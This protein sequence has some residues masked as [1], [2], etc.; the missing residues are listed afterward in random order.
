MSLR[1]LLVEDLLY[2][3]QSKKVH[4]DVDQS[5]LKEQSWISEY[6]VEL[7]VR[8]LDELAYLLVQ[9]VLDYLLLVLTWIEVFP[10]LDDQ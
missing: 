6:W 2:Y 8:M 3:H 10:A 7:D 1:Y 4:V 9:E 5:L